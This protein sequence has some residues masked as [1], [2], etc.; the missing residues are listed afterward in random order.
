MSIF[1]AFVSLFL[2]PKGTLAGILRG[3]GHQNIGAVGNFVAFYVI[4]LPLGISLA[5]AAHM[6]ALGMWL[7]LLAGSLT[8]ASD[9]W[10]MFTQLCINFF[11]P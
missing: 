4:G 10:R 3:C 6:G 1:A 2:V 9:N 11:L 7:G 5:L 8:Q